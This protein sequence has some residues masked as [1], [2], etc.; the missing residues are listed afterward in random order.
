M[1]L[2]LTTAIV[3]TI[4]S[5]IGCTPQEEKAVTHDP[6]STVSPSEV[7]ISKVIESLDHTEMVLGEIS[8]AAEAAAERAARGGKIFV[9][10]DETVTRT[11]AEETKMIPGGGMEYPMHEDWGGFVAE[12]CDRA[13]GLRHIQPVPINNEVSENDIVLVGTVD[14]RADIQAEQIRAIRDHGALVIVFGSR[15]SAVAELGDYFIDNGFGAGTVTV[16]R[17]KSTLTGPVAP[18]ANVINKGGFT[19]EYVAA[20]TR[21]GKMPALWQSMFMP[22][23]APRNKR[24]GDFLYHPDMTIAPV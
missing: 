18:I 21:V 1:R 2:V 9:T 24:I 3:F 17:I 8:E 20:L 7:F 23:A 6:Q 12:A 4:I 22:G 13:G 5:G 16:M 19:A 15:E 11:G 14:L 10:D